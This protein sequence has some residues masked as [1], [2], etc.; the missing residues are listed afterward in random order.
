METHIYHTVN[1]GVY[2]E[3]G[4]T[5]I[6]I[7]GLFDGLV[8]GY[9]K[10]PG[11]VLDACFHKSPPFQNLKALLFTHKHFDHFNE[12]MLDIIRNQNEE[13]LVYAPAYEKSNINPQVVREDVVYFKVGPFRIYA[14]RTMHDGDASLR[15]EPHVSFVINTD[16]ETFFF[17]GDALFRTGEPEKIESYCDNWVD[18]AFINPYHTMHSVNRALLRKLDPMKVALIHKSF[19]ED[20]TYNM[21]KLFEIALKHY[22]E[23]LPELIQ[24]G[25]NT[26]IQ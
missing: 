7:D 12:N 13:M 17:A 10:T 16:D 4:D 21:Y 26:W 19:K 18:Y 14:I 9:S 24:P 25:F 8:Y 1:C 22:P 2:F 23:D 5:G 11:E 3:N 15:A 20:D 6:F